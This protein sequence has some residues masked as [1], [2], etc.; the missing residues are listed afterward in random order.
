LAGFG[1]PAEQASNPTFG[2]VCRLAEQKGIDLLLAALPFA[3]RQWRMNF[4]ALASGD[5]RLE[6]GLNALRESFPQNVGVYIGFDPKLAHRIEG[7]ADFFVM[8][9]RYEPCGLNQMYSLRYGTVPVVR[10]TG[11]LD[12]TV[13]DVGL[14]DGTGIKFSHFTRDD[15]THALWRGIRLYGNPSWMDQVRARGMHTDF[16]WGASAEKYESLYHRLV[17]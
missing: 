10:A 16:S 14:P 6:H 15:L 4:V 1:L 9:S 5:G 7:G 2:L 13:V 11:G 3:L 17:R 12:D 8:P